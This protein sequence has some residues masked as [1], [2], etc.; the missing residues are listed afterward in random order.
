MA[1][2]KVGAIKKDQQTGLV[3]VD[4]E[5]C[6]GCMDCIAACPFG[7]ASWDPANKAIAMCD[8]CGTCVE[9][10]PP[11]AINFVDR[12]GIIREKKAREIAKPDIEREGE[13][14]PP[15]PEEGLK[16]ETEE[17]ARTRKL[18]IR[19]LAS[20]GITG[21][22]KEPTALPPGRMVVGETKRPRGRK[23]GK[24]G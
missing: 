5:L 17:L 11:K 14:W 10:C 7:A 19:F 20:E 23:G 4:E 12:P 21:Y 22:E 2:C 15:M 8:Q 9:W 6:V 1:V 13:R 3:A 16:Y 18:M 24:S